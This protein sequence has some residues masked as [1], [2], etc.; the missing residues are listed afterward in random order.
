MARMPAP[1]PHVVV[2]S[3]HALAK[4]HFLGIPRVD[5]EEALLA[6]HGS[7]ERNTGAA[8]WLLRHGRL[9]IAYNFP[10]EGDELVAAVVTIWRRR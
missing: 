3:D 2:W 4:A 8:D 7:R 5:V 9:A 10:G 1:E 6:F